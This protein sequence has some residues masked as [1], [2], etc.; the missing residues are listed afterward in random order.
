L[1]LLRQ[2]FIPSVLVALTGIVLPFL[3]SFL[4]IP[5]SN[6]DIR[7]AIAAA[8]ALSSTSLGTICDILLRAKLIKSNVGTVIVTA[9][10]MDDVVGFIMVSVIS[11]IG[12]ESNG[13]SIVQTVL[14]SLGAPLVFMLICCAKKLCPKSRLANWVEEHEF[15]KAVWTIMILGPLSAAEYTR[16]SILFVIYL[17]GVST[18]YLLKDSILAK[19]DQ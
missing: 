14:C 6:I 5:I 7:T 4:L 3:L 16:A 1:K 19:Y 15:D 17:S 10:M 12:E 9:A 8:V 13:K 11:S 18:S 2:N